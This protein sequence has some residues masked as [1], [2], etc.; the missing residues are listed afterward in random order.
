MP[1][2]EWLL[3][4]SENE[5]LSEVSLDWQDKAPEVQFYWCKDPFR[6]HILEKREAQRSEPSIQNVFFPLRHLPFFM[7]N[8]L[9][10]R[11]SKQK[12]VDKF[13]NSEAD[14]LVAS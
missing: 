4:R 9:G 2:R 10:G 7:Q 11:E 6:K 5:E 1:D 14:L 13:L 12:A 8:R 3:R